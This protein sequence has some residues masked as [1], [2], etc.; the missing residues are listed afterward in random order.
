MAT[1]SS[2]IVILPFQM[3]VENSVSN[4]F[5]NQESSLNLDDDSKAVFDSFT[6]KLKNLPFKGDKIVD[7]SKY[8]DFIS[9]YLSQENDENNNSFLKTFTIDL[10]KLYGVNESKQKITF[11]SQFQNHKLFL[12]E[13]DLELKFDKITIVLNEIAKL[14]Y[15]I[16]K[17]DYIVDNE[18]TLKSLS[19]IDF[20]RYYKPNEI[21]N[22]NKLNIKYAIKTSKEKKDK[23]GNLNIDVNY[24]PLFEII[25][26]YFSFLNT[27]AYFMYAKPIMLHLFSKNENNITS[28]SELIGICYKVLRIPPKH[29]EFETKLKEQQQ[30]KLQYPDNN[31]AYCTMSEGSVVIDSTTE[32]GTTNILLNKYLLAF[33]LALNQR[34]V[35]LKTAKDISQIAN[36][37]LNSNDKKTFLIL[38]QLRKKLNLIQLKQIF[39]NISLNNEIGLFFIDL[40]KKFSIDILLKDNNG[41]IEAIHSLLESE[42]LKNEAVENKLEEEAQ[43]KRD[44]NLAFILGLVGLFGAASAVIDVYNFFTSPDGIYYWW[45]P[46]SIVIFLG[47]YLVWYYKKK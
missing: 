36:E 24:I 3:V 18:T 33:L 16:F 7:T 40:Q 15:L 35:M 14:G 46:T 44:N 31:I 20:Y 13:S 41:S 19:E 42:R 37:N 1:N 2:S 47:A 12:G 22:K 26:T 28:E 38:G 25:N 32:N 23:D 17:I 21:L 10:G 9:N 6:N 11:A 5:E 43:K 45:L 34:E 8:L 30:I 27:N 39:Y 29:V 4:A